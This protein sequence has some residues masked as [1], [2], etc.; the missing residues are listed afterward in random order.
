ME[1]LVEIYQSA[2]LFN[3]WPDLSTLLIPA[4]LA[5]ALFVMSFLLFRR[6]S[7]ELVDVL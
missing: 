4:G 7:A 1:A 2:R 5:L 3:R 6:A